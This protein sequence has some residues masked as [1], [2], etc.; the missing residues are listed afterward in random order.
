MSDAVQPQW[1]SRAEMVAV[2]RTPVQLLGTCS[3]AACAT[4]GYANLANVPHVH[5]HAFRSHVYAQL[6][7]DVPHVPA[8]VGHTALVHAA[9]NLDNVANVPVP[10]EHTALDHAAANRPHVPA[11]AHFCHGTNLQS[12]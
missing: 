3:F 5:A 11:A 8:P 12:I 10:V 9:A 7:A 4:A 6:H 2:I 1:S